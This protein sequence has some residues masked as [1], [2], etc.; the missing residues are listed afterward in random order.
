[1]A[2]DKNGKIWFNGELVDWKNANIHVLSHVVHY[3]S[4]V[5][6]G[7]RCYHNKQGSAV[8]RLAEHVERLFDSA[9]IYRMEISYTPAEISQAIQETI[10]TNGLKECYIRPVV[11][12]GQ[13]EL[14]VNPLNSPLEVVIAAWK[15]GSYLGQEAVEVGVDVGVSTWR[16]MAPD[17]LPNMAKAGAN[18]M[19]SQLVKMEALENGYDEGIL[20]DYQG[21]ISEGSGENIFL[22]KDEVIYTPPLA[23]SL[24]KGITRDSVITLAREM[25]L[26][27][28]EEQMPR[29][30]LYVADEIFLT[31]TAA[32]VTPI[33]S[34]DRINVGS[35]GRGPVTE[36]LQQ[37]F[38]QILRAEVDDRWGWLT[39]LD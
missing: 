9:R 25:D 7:I 12:R 31:G 33:R 39:Y 13:G 23:S 8:F 38:F 6:E 5:F 36:K 14:G 27:V 3:G 26:E 29:E 35:G 21:M 16:R 30:M 20:L 15:W 37:A 32:E 28:R 22:I 1:M 17:T 2:W 19:N 4:S 18:Y 11:F 34:V 24:L 10:K